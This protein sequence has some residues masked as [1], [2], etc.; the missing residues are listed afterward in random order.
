MIARMENASAGQR[1]LDRCDSC[2]WWWPT[3][4][5]PSQISQVGRREAS[6]HN[7]KYQYDYGS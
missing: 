3:R 2:S 6:S 1:L 7:Y 4:M 5:I